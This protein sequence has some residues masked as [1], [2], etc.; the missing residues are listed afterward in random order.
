MRLNKAQRH[1]NTNFYHRPAVSAF[2]PLFYG[3]RDDMWY[4]GDKS[5]KAI[6]GSCTNTVSQFAMPPLHPLP[7]LLP[8][9]TP[10]PTTSSTT[11][12]TMMMTHTNKD[13]STKCCSKR[14]KRVPRWKRPVDKPKRPASAYNLFFNLE[15]QRLLNGDPKC[16][17]NEIHVAETAITQ[18]IDKP[19]RLHVKTHGRIGFQDLSRTIAHAWRV[20]PAAERSIF[21][22]QAAIETELYAKRLALWKATT[23][24]NQ[25]TSIVTTNPKEFSSPPFTSMPVSNMNG[26]MN[27][28]APSLIKPPSFNK[29]SYMLERRISFTSSE[30]CESPPSPMSFSTTTSSS[31][32]QGRDKT[33]SPGWTPATSMIFDTEEED[34]EEI[35]EDDMEQSRNS[36][37]CC[38]KMNV[39]NNDNDLLLGRSAEEISKEV[40]EI[41]A[42]EQLPIFVPTQTDET[43]G[44]YLNGVWQSCVPVPEIVASTPGSTEIDVCYPSYPGCCK[45][46]PIC[47]KETSS[48]VSTTSEPFNDELE[49]EEEV[50]SSANVQ[51]DETDK[52]DTMELQNEEQVENNDDDYDEVMGYFFKVVH[53]ADSYDEHDFEQMAAKVYFDDCDGQKLD[54]YLF[55]NKKDITTQQ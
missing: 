49:D 9:A 23:S 47:N 48:V 32:V 34:E 27:H 55:N 3:S 12:T 14:K 38:G 43:T 4:K 52:R 45:L 15:R 30:C 20:L 6:S 31:S 24:S 42:Q 17:Y 8:A 37:D 41:M 16:I 36:K 18:R 46:N 50:A 54:N 25:E 22:K 21:D 53:F 7:T 39:Q 11:T 40:Y 5:N 29:S 2:P 51:F 1:Q 26:H 10:I 35:D 28:T 13:G 44:H 19:K 33:I